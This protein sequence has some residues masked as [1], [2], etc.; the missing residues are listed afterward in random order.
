MK[1][2]IRSFLT[3]ALMPFGTALSLATVPAARADEAGAAAAF[4]AAK[5]NSARLR[6]FLQ[7]MPKGGDLH[8]HLSGTPYAEDYLK[9]AADKGLCADAAGTALTAPPC[10]T[11]RTIEVL[12]EKD[13]FAFARLVD[14]LSTRGFQKGV[15]AG[16]IS[17]HDQFFR[18]FGRFEPAF[19]ADVARWLAVARRNAAR[20]HVSYLELMHDPKPL[21]DYTMEAG[22]EVVTVDQIGAIY[23][24]EAPGLAAVIKQGM[25]EMD[26][27]EAQASRDLG[28]GAK[29]KAVGAACDVTVRYLGFAWRGVAPARAFRSLLAAFALADADPRFVG[30]NIVMPEDDPVALRD[31]DLHMAMF[32]FLAARYPKVRISMHAG[33]LALGL[34]PPDDLR[35]HIAEAVASGAQRIGHGTAIAYEDDAEATLARMARDHVAVEVNLTSNAVIL[36]VAGGTHPFQLYRSHGVPVVLS[37]DDAG[38]LRSDLTN[39]YQRAVTEQ[40]MGYADLKTLA[41]ASIEYAFIADNEKAR[42]ATDLE[43][44]FNRFESSF[45]SAP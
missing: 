21:V 37:T 19:G 43:A 26:Q 35:D 34:V 42:L 23:K 1:V 15:G 41:R 25:A 28:C 8:N 31:Y 5:G 22:D 30:V 16:S 33:E 9:V 2:A 11:E 6:V 24:R 45:G 18:S 36:G 44:Q 32:R 14:G 13:P 40:G 4:E 29:A 7:A 20:D 39:E 10:P 12:A 3:Y 27:T 17:G 38:V